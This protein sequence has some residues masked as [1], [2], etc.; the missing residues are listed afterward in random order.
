MRFFRLDTPLTMAPV[1]A[2][3]WNTTNAGQLA[4]QKA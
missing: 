2:H 4:R 3:V 1:S